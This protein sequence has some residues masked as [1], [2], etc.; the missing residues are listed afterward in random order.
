MIAGHAL[1]PQPLS[2]EGVN[3]QLHCVVKE[4]GDACQGEGGEEGLG[5]KQAGGE[6]LLRAAKEQCQPVWTR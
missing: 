2:D 4:N 5:D 1:F 3:N 6:R